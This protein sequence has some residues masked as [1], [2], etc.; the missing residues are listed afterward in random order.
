MGAELS[1]AC[2]ESFD[3]YINGEHTF[4]ATATDFSPAISRS[5]TATSSPS[6]AKASENKGGFCIKIQFPSGHFL[7]TWNGWKVYTPADPDNWFVPDRIKPSGAITK[8]TGWAEG[9]M[10]DE[11]GKKK[12]PIPQIWG[13]GKT[14]YLAM[15]AD[16]SEEEDRTDEAGQKR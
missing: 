6:S 8:G 5:P 4:R 2:E 1:V 14:I 9:L 3:L 13:T 16:T 11:T 15:Q 12:M 7:S 10:K